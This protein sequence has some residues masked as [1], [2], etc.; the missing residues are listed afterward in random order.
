MIKSLSC[1][2]DKALEHR[3][4]LSFK[5]TKG[6]IVE[7][8]WENEVHEDVV[9]LPRSDDLFSLHHAHDF[10]HVRH[11]KSVN[12]SDHVCFIKSKNPDFNRRYIVVQ[13]RKLLQNILFQG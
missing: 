4:V 8:F 7:T 11:L 9:S 10:V 5:V 6:E 12:I 1:Y 2:H 3:I 13:H